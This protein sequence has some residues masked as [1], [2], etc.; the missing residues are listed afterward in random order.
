MNPLVLVLAIIAFVLQV[1][2][3]VGAT[4]EV[5]LGVARID[6]Y[7]TL[8]VGKSMVAPKEFGASPRVPTKP[9]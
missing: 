2:V 9:P 3:V 6:Q 1:L 7:K 8:D 5:K 4:R